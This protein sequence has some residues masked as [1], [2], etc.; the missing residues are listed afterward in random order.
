MQSAEAVRTKLVTEVK[1]LK[2][3]DVCELQ[4]KVGLMSDG[5]SDIQTRIIDSNNLVHELQSSIEQGNDR[6]AQFEDFVI[7]K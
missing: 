4:K 3:G 5:I 1:E 2:K 7:Y 6:V